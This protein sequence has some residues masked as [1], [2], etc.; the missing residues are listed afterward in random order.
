MVWNRV[1]FLLVG[2]F[3]GVGSA[4]QPTIKNLVLEGGGIR[5]IAYIGALQ[6]LDSA[7]RLRSL[8]RVG[9]TSAGAIMACLL[10][11]GYTPEETLEVLTSTSFKKFNDGSFLAIPG[12]LRLRK[13]MGWYRGEALRRWLEEMIAEK[14][15]DG[16][17]TFRQ[18]NDQRHRYG[19]VSL[20]ITGTDLSW[21]RLR[22]F[23]HETFPDMRVADAVRISASIPFYFKPLWMDSTG[24]C[25]E[26]NDALQ[27]RW[28]MADGGLLANYPLNLFDR[29][30]YMAVSSGNEAGI[31][32]HTIG[33]QLEEPWIVDS[34]ALYR[35]KPFP[36]ESNRDYLKTIY[37][38]L[39]DK[40]TA[41]RDR[42]VFISNL[43]INPRVR[44]LP[45]HQIQELLESGRKAARRHLQTH[46]H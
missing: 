24:R 35:A 38:L 37:K 3:W 45:S 25:F 11:V 43:G 1:I 14:T 41:D 2:L 10:A 16:N 32:K 12:V 33:L 27:S 9:G 36:V 29:S 22:V 30:P 46:G 17:I 21:Q 42:T 39:V 19:R 28:L 34:P 5:G 6:V 40:P 44:R 8:E 31:N 20:Y 15:G 7:D 4:A 18:L 26:T 23:S 13:K